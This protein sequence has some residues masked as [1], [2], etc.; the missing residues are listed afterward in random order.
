MAKTTI[1]ATIIVSIHIT[2]LLL[3]ISCFFFKVHASTV[4]IRHDPE[5][6]NHKALNG[7]K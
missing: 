4:Q 3:T 6:L 5:P 1:M 2:L 7:Y